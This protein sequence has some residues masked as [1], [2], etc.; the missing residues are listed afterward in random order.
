MEIVLNELSVKD[1][2]GTPDDAKLAMSA[3]LLVCKKAR[4]EIGCNRLRLPNAEFF[5]ADLV[6]GYTINQWLSDNTISQTERTLF[7]GLRRFPYFEDLNEEQENRFIL[8]KFFLNEEEHEANGSEVH[9]LANAWLKQTLAVSLCS[10]PVWA[11]SNIGL[12]I[13]NDAD[14]PQTVEVYN[15]CAEGSVSEEFK[16]W[17]RKNHLPPLR[18]HED[19]DVWFPLEAGYALSGKAKDDLIYW[20]QE[21]HND[22][23]E[24]IESF[25]REIWADPFRGTG[26]VEPLGQNLSGWWSRRINQE[27]RLVYKFESGV[28]HVCSCKGHYE[29]LGCD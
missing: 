29:S 2:S 3:L 18:T 8:S 13:T 4:D 5:E 22:K 10:H 25:F 17:F 21:N 27:H 15:A 7:N 28:I 11:K 26:Q 12:T 16:N 1:L 19:V 20:F 24:K 6:A 9:G 23:I 14:E